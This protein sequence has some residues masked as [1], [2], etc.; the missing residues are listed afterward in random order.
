[1]SLSGSR[2]FIRSKL[3][4]AAPVEKEIDQTRD[5]VSSK[6]DD[7]TVKNERSM[8]VILKEARRRFM[9]RGL[10][11]SIDISGSFSIFTSSVIC[12][13]GGSGTDSITSES[14]ELEAST[15]T[16]ATDES[17]SQE[18]IE[19]LKTMEKIILSYLDR[20]LYLLEKRAAA[21][22]SLPFS[23][24]VSLSSGVKI[25]D[26]IFGAASISIS[27]TAT[28]ASIFKNQSK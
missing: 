13:I 15:T 16:V 12:N 14:I 2:N 10:V 5:S 24:S 21:Y 9:A 8:M 7:E 28:V 3:G 11:G 19:K 17:E 6:Q 18:E 27:L 4:I 26:P 20:V 22:R 25:S 1:M 23:D